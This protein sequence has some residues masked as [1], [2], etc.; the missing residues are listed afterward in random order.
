MPS[1][2]AK[3]YSKILKQMCRLYR[4]PGDSG[5]GFDGFVLKAP[6]QPGTGRRG[7]FSHLHFAREVLSIFPRLFKEVNLVILKKV[8]S[9]SGKILI[10]AS[11]LLTLFIVSEA[12]AQSCNCYDSVS[13]VQVRRAPVRRVVRRAH[14]V[15][16]YTTVSPTATYTAYTPVV[17]EVRYAPRYVAYVDDND[18]DETAYTPAAQVYVTEPVYTAVPAR[19]V[20]YTNGYN[21]QVTYTTY[22]PDE[23]TYTTTSPNVI[24]NDYSGYDTGRIARGWGHRDGF[25]DGYKAALKFRA[26][27]PQNNGDYW[28]ANNGYKRRFGDKYLYKSS[29]RSGYA[30]GYDE[31]FRSVNQNRVIN[32]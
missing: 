18:C 32:Y 10:L 30:V 25:K 11:F 19:N 31:G 1:S 6:V 21:R 17:R 4:S 2:G 24:V 15:R 5:F 14:V 9:I 8:S 23:V 20:H 13:T 22:A 26:Y 16:T 12:P 29:Y 3:E 7:R 28:D 27:D